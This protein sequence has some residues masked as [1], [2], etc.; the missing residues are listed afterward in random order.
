MVWTTVQHC[1]DEV[2]RFSLESV[3]FE[4]QRKKSLSGLRANFVL[5]TGV[6]SELK[7]LHKELQ[8]C[9]NPVSVWK[10]ENWKFT[11]EISKQ[12][13]GNFVLLHHQKINTSA[14]I[15]HKLPA[16]NSVFI[17]YFTYSVRAATD[18]HIY[19]TYVS[20]KN[21]FVCIL[22]CDNESKIEQRVNQASLCWSGSHMPHNLARWQVW[23]CGVSSP[24]QENNVVFKPSRESEPQSA[25]KI[26]GFQSL[27]LY[28]GELVNKEKEVKKINS[29]F[30]I[31]LL[32]NYVLK[33]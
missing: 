19:I 7:R 23:S 24:S 33:Q 31:T 4:E 28:K 17:F 10:K 1:P 32:C 22:L 21:H 6:K 16:L 13:Q 27:V 20:I 5:Y 8:L 26:T 2:T 14:S 29:G 18:L 3:T 25:G 15:S 12:E 11:S 9:F 30:W